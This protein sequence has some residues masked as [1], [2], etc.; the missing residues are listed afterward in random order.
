V[1][2][3]ESDSVE[4]RSSIARARG[5]DKAYTVRALTLLAAVALEVDPPSVGSGLLMSDDLVA[6]AWV[7]ARSRSSVEKVTR[8]QLLGG[9]ALT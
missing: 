4:T 1:A 2:L 6:R 9:A 3:S 7:Y 8:A 5:D